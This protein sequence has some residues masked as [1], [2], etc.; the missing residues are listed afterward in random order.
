M[1][2]F[3]RYVDVLR[4][5]MILAKRPRPRRLNAHSRRVIDRDVYDRSGAHRLQSVERDSKLQVYSKL[6]VFYNV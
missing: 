1:N 5:Q 3:T 2:N 6:H 4:R